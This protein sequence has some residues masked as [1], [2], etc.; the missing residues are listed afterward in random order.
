MRKQ[1]SAMRP[2]NKREENLALDAP[3]HSLELSL[4]IVQA[5]NVTG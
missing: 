2:E 3:F 1:K 4:S 5:S